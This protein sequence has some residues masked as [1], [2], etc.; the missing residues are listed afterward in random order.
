MIILTDKLFIIEEVKPKRRFFGLLA[1]EKSIERYVS[2]DFDK[3]L[4]YLKKAEEQ[5][6]ENKES[7]FVLRGAPPENI[8]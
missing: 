4:A 2:Q 3:A 8:C 1:G 7:H 5:L 6:K